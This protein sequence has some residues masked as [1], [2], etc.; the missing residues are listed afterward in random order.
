MASHSCWLFNQIP[1][2]HP[3]WTLAVMA[4]SVTDARQ[5]VKAAYGGGKLVKQVPSGRVDA[6]CGLTTE[7]ASE[8][9]RNA[10]AK[11]LLEMS[12]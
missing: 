4:V 2:T 11:A 1:G 9:M 8:A 3:S 10:R 6:D 5:A 12:A 7:L